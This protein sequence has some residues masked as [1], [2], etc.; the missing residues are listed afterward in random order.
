[1]FNV[2]ARLVFSIA[3]I[4]YIYAAIRSSF[5]SLSSISFIRIAES[6]HLR[7]RRN[8]ISRIYSL[9][10]CRAGLPTRIESKRPLEPAA[11][12][13]TFIKT[14]TNHEPGTTLINGKSLRKKLEQPNRRI[15]T[16]LSKK[17]ENYTQNGLPS[18]RQRR[19]P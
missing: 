7:A 2:I 6:N 3:S 12:T 14:E 1:V 8:T 18:R 19:Y 4:L 11:A 15:E 10:T 17:R 9:Y 5:F 13:R 16:S